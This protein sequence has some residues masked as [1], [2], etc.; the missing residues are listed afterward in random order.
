M[1]NRATVIFTDGKKSFSPAI[2]LHW[3]G[4]P[5][6][7]YGFLE[8][9]DRR[10]V[11]ADQFYEAARFT[12]IVGEFFNNGDSISGL[13]LGLSNGPHSDKT[14]DLDKVQSDHG[15]NGFYLVN[16]TKNAEFPMRRFHEKY[17][18]DYVGHLT[19]DS[20]EFVEAEKL[21]ADKSDYRPQFRE[22]YAKLTA[23]K[24]IE[25]M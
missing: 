11:R 5:E 23:N 25:S 17:S 20:R 16:R 15:D 3:N 24:K 6:S 2:Y 18:K 21:E 19:E 1:G 10:G 9:L 13:S 22:F 14:T 8:E 4:G 12:Q 7:I